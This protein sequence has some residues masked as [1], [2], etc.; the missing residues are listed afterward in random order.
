MGLTDRIAR[1]A[2][3]RPHVLVVTVPG[4]DLERMRVQKVVRRSGWVLAQSPADADLLVT[5]GAAGDDLAV[6]IDRVWEQMPAPRARILVTAG[7][8]IAAA[9]RGAA[10][11]LADIPL[12]RRMLSETGPA[13]RNGYGPGAVHAQMTHESG[14]DG[15]ADRGGGAPHLM[16]TESGHDRTDEDMGSDRDMENTGDEPGSHQGGLHS[17]HGHGEMDM[18]MDMSG[19]GGVPLAGGYGADRDGLEMDVLHLPLGPVLP[20]WP[21]GLVLDCTLSGDLVVTASTR[22]LPAAGAAPDEPIAVDHWRLVQHLDAAAQILHLVGPPGAASR[23]AS[24]RD[25]ALD[26][27]AH[28]VSHAAVVS[29]GRRVAR[30]KLLRWSLT[31]RHSGSDAGGVL[32][33]LTAHLAAAE[34]N[35][36]GRASSGVD[37]VDVDALADQIQGRLLSDVHAIVAGRAVRPPDPVAHHG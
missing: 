11:S 15:H 29:L 34:A 14:T 22:L 26:E 27:Q 6:L 10:A 23:A 33:R 3:Q 21:A 25:A 32:G 12:Q 8:E 5:V 37:P 19:P 35:T 30:S 20:D 17:M 24:L 36:A 16:T 31:A 4:W 18:S 13:P 28:P 9:L 7:D 2:A 1:L